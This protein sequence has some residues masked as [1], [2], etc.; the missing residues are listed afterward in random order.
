MQRQALDDRHVRTRAFDKRRQPAAQVGGQAQ[1][2]RLA[3]VGNAPHRFGG[4][5]RQRQD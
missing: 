3:P 2:A 1:L 5:I 4:H